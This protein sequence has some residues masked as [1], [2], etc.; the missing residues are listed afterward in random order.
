[1]SKRILLDTNILVYS[2]DEASTFFGQVGEAI[3]GIKP[4]TPQLWKEII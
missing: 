2:R 3:K 4:F 1:M